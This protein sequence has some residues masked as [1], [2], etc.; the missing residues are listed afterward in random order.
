MIF[1]ETLRLDKRNLSLFNVIIII[2]RIIAVCFVTITRRT[3]YVFN[4]ATYHPHKLTPIGTRAW[5]H[6]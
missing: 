2:I 1:V 5:V 6:S 3:N 4:I